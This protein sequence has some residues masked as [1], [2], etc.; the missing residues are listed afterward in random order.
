M[1]DANQPT[2]IALIRHGQTEWNAFGRFQGS[3]DTDLNDIGRAQAIEA[4][5]WLRTELP[6]ANWQAMRY[7]PL[8][9]AAETGQLIADAL[10]VDEHRVLPSLS[11]RDWGAAEGLTL[12]ECEQRWPQLAGLDEMTARDLFAGA[13]PNELVIARGRFALATLAAQYPGG[14]VLATAHGTVLRETL[15]D[16]LGRRFGYVPNAGVIVLRIQPDAAELRCELLARS[17]KESLDR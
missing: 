14:Q 15:T 12:A 5:D 13:E 16:V 1:T 10:G 17:F 7:S 11:E 6:E 2:T 4:A 3:T 8:R 9:R